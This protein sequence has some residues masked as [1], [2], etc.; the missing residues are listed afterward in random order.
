M[1]LLDQRAQ[2]Q[3]VI[4][5]NGWLTRVRFVEAHQNSDSHEDHPDR[6]AY[7][8]ST[9]EEQLPNDADH[10]SDVPLRRVNEPFIAHPVSQSHAACYITSSQFG[11]TARRRISFR[12]ARLHPHYPTL[13]SILPDSGKVRPYESTDAGEL[14]A[15]GYHRH[16]S[17][18]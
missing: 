2:I 15:D 14:C 12:L 17:K 9:S 18:Y 7:R 8:L 16:Q 5:L 13:H 11:N 3:F 1:S 6:S 10:S 4:H